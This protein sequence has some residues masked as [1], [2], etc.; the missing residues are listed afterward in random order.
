MTEKDLRASITDMA[1]HN[2]W[3]I[4]LEIPDALY[5]HIATVNDR[6]LIPSARALRGIPDLWIGNRE[7]G[8]NIMLEL[9]TAKGGPNEYQKE[10][11]PQLI[12][13]GMTVAITRP[14]DYDTLQAILR[15]ERDW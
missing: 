7:Q 9:K 8:R 2:G 11:I 5:R 4:L 10:K 13:C 12:A 15:G 1:L 6:R 14:R 3:E